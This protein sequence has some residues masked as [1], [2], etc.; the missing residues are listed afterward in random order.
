MTTSRVASWLLGQPVTDKNMHGTPKVKPRHCQLN[1]QIDRSIARI[2]LEMQ[3]VSLTHW[4]S[5]TNHHHDIILH[6]AQY[7]AAGYGMHSWAL[8]S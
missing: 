5:G 1:L 7:T 4:L 3:N 8:S 6:C 2:S